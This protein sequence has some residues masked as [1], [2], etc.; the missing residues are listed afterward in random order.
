[1]IFD[2]SAGRLFQVLRLGLVLLW[3]AS[4]IT[5]AAALPSPPLRPISTLEQPSRVLEDN[6]D[7]RWLARDVSTADDTSSFDPLGRTPMGLTGE[8]TNVP[9]GWVDPRARGGRMLDVG[10]SV[11]ELRRHRHIEHSLTKPL[12]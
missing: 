10:P 6:D 7:V 8:P 12:M 5:L 4:A 3:T 1:M 9:M 11:I 2:P